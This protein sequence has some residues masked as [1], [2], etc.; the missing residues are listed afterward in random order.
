MWGFVTSR[1]AAIALLSL[2]TMVSAAEIARPQPLPRAV[3]V[4]QAA[5]GELDLVL[6]S[7]NFVD[8]VIH[9]LPVDAHLQLFR[10]LAPQAL[11]SAL[12]SSARQ[13]AFWLNVYNGYTQHFL[14][15]DPSTYLEDRPKYFGMDQ[16]EIAGETVSLEHIEHGVL[17]RGA[18][19]YTL[20]H[21][22]I[23]FLRRQFVRRFA[24]DEVDYRI[25]FAL[26]CGA[27]SCPPVIPYTAAALDE[28]LDAIS[29]DYLAREAEYDA[30]ADR[31]AV[32]ALMRWFSADFNGGS[33]DAKR[34]ILHRHGVLP[35]E[36]AASLDYRAYDWTLAIDNY[37]YY[38][39]E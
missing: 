3:V 16:I 32:P 15:R 14:K 39:P 7:A 23:L 6:L 2:A 8:R 11:D 25:H 21:L 19:I 30:A 33:R 37:A 5:L 9:D 36:S 12:D 29:R 13:R 10:S 20:G 27:L 34:K 38:R 26:N 35:A 4:D 17:R 28:Q 18:T 31:V 1:C 22:R 24:V